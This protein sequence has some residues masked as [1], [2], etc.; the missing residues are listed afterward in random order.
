MKKS[1]RNAVA[2]RVWNAQGEPVVTGRNAN[3]YPDNNPKTAFGITKPSLSKVPPSVM[4]YLALG[5][6][7]G[8]KKYGAYNWRTKNVTASIYVD[9]C[10]RHLQ[11]WFDGEEYARD[12]GFPHLA[13]ALACIAILVDG[14]ENGSLIDDRPPPG[15]MADLIETW[16]ER[17]KERARAAEAA[18]QPLAKTAERTKRKARTK[19]KKK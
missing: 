4:L 18:A 13:H 19:G 16:T 3:S 6:M 9:A 12:S 14:K 7:D 17:L 8:A 10:L 5:F 1:S 11:S 15:A 2:P